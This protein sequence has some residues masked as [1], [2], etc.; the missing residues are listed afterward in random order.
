MKRILYEVTGNGNNYIAKRV[1]E[2]KS[3]GTDFRKPSLWKM[4]ETIANAHKDM[5]MVSQRRD[6]N[7]FNTWMILMEGEE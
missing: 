5:K 3:Y 7:K 6:Q 2:G 4:K 1:T